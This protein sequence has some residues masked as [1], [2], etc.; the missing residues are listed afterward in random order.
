MSSPQKQ[1]QH[2]SSGG[3]LVQDQQAG[4]TEAILQTQCSGFICIAAI[5]GNELCKAAPKSS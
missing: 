3:H 1:G 4:K 5:Q 2:H